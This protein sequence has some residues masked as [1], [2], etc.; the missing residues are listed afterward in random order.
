MKGLVSTL[1]YRE[2]HSDSPDADA[3]ASFFGAASVGST[4]GKPRSSG[5][6][7]QGKTTWLASG[8]RKVGGRENFQVQSSSPE[9]H[10]R[11]QALHLAGLARLCT[12]HRHAERVV[13]CPTGS[14]SMYQRLRDSHGTTRTCNYRLHDHQSLPS[15]LHASRTIAPTTRPMMPGA[16]MPHFQP[17]ALAKP[18]ATSGA[19]K[20]PRLCAMFHIPQYVPRS[21]PANQVVRMRAQHGPPTPCE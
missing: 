8:E 15:H 17:M 21:G 2:S 5:L 13:A 10:C 14:I 19:A 16:H 6:S 12:T 1:L 11:C 18:P 4:A 7:L 9:G 20:P 3:L